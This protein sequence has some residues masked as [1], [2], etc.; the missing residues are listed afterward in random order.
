[1]STI[2][3]NRSSQSSGVAL[4][5]G[6]CMTQ[7][8]FHQTYLQLPGDVKAELIGGIVY[9]AEPLGQ[10]H[11]SSDMQL[12]SVFDAYR[13]STP[14]V[15]ACHNATVIL[16]REDEVQPDLF[17]RIL[18]GFHGQS[19][20]TRK[21][22]YVKG[23]PEL[24]AEIAYSS[25]SIDLHVKRQ[26]YVSGGVIEYIVVC[27]QPMEVHWFDL[28]NDSELIADREGVFRSSV[29]P[30]LWIHGAGLLQLD[31]R[32]V[33]DVLNRGLSSPEHGHFAAKLSA[34]RG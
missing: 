18:P 23:P 5:N 24:V 1:V 3:K 25:R 21:G 22:T 26:R 28:L 19:K 8:E 12:G 4:R 14:G 33:M 34:A 6:D 11:G 31:Y 20:N 30:G 17:L 16:G 27:L 2:P 10:D 13:A 32:L 9:V 15:Q 7:K 29:F